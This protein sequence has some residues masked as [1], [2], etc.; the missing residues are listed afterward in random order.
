[1]KCEKCGF[2][3]LDKATFCI[4]CGSRLD[5]KI[6]CPKCGEY[7]SNDAQSCPHCHKAIPHA[8]ESKIKKDLDLNDKQAKIATVF[9]RVSFA[10]SIFLV[11]LILIGNVFHHF[12]GVSNTYGEHLPH[13]TFFYYQALMNFNAFPTVDKVSLIIG[14]IT[15]FLDFVITIVFSIMI[16]VRLKR[17]HDKNNLPS[18]YKYFAVILATKAFSFA[19]IG[20]NDYGETYGVTINV[21]SLIIMIS[22]LIIHL[23][24]AVGFDCFLHFKTRSI[25]I[26]IARI[27]LGVGIFVPLVMILTC[28][29]INLGFE[30]AY[31]G[32]E[33]EFRLIGHLARYFLMCRDLGS[34]ATNEAFIS[35]FITSTFS[36]T[37]IFSLISVCFSLFVYSFSCYFKG[38]NKFKIFRIMFYLLVIALSILSTSLLVSVALEN[39]LYAL[40]LK[41]N[42]DFTYPNAVISIFTYSV[43]LV[44]VAIATFNIYNRANRRKA[45]EEKTAHSK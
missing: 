11:V 36:V 4:K 38:M 2:D 19:F 14:Y 31:I 40:Y 12:I 6:P 24:I 27:I 44:G 34:N 37:I 15:N 8:S 10:V 20:L 33:V 3:N 25:S 21:L 28:S 17:L 30:Y 43:L 29:S 16:I 22:A 42:Y 39:H 23:F 9:N 26:F 32:H 41:S 1:M 35:T 45:L 5:G 13:F 7:I 18:L